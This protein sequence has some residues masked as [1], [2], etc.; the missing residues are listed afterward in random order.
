[1]IVVSMFKT[2][3]NPSLEPAY[4]VFSVPICVLIMWEC[5]EPDA[6]DTQESK[7]WSILK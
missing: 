1:M 5:F 6:W 3:P 7:V 2:A 4:F